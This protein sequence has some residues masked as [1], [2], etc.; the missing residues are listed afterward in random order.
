MANAAEK[1]PKNE[2][3][4]NEKKEKAPKKSLFLGITIL[5]NTLAM[6]AVVYLVMVKRTEKQ[7]TLSMEEI[8]EGAG[9]DQA[10][11][12]A[13]GTAGGI[14][15]PLDHFLVNLSGEL[16]H[17]IFKVKMEFDVDS[18]DVQDEIDKR[19]PRIR[20]IIIILLSSKN[21]SQVSTPK[22]KE[23]LKEEIRDT[24]NSFL[25]KGKVNK[26]LFTKFIYS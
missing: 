19:M 24:V 22:G 9:E 18:S 13:A 16:G 6:I 26:V 10:T 5:V 25:R 15:I 23:K 11:A 2:A 12:N 8:V 4:Q 3:G 1:Q 14:V 17:K 21:Y 20:D 7:G